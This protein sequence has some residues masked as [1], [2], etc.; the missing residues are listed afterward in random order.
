MRPE[1]QSRAQLQ[2]NLGISAGLLVEDMN[3]V[4]AIRQNQALLD[5]NVTDFVDP[6]RQ[7]VFQTEL[8]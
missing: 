8:L 3:S 5:R 6:Q 2:V 1:V 7:S 4:V